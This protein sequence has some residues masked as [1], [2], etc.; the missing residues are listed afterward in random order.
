MG[1]GTTKNHLQLP[2]AMFLPQ[3]MT[4]T[5][6]QIRYTEMLEMLFACPSYA[7]RMSFLCQLYVFV[8]H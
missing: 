3:K 5:N 7:I 8:Y 2:E 1:I 6:H 4:I